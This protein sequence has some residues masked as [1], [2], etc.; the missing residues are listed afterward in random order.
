MFPFE[1]YT[2]FLEEMGISQRVNMG[3]DV[4]ED[5][6]KSNEVYFLQV[7]LRNLPE[8]G[9]LIFTWLSTSASDSFCCYKM[10]YSPQEAPG[11]SFQEE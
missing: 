11:P 3:M 6:D 7:T 2:P 8:R 5:T 1:V 4:T 10:S 9:S